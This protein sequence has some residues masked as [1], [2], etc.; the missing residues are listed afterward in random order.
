MNMGIGDSL[1]KF[2][3]KVK[4]DL[5][6]WN[7]NRII[8]DLEKNQVQKICAITKVTHLRELCVYYGR[9]MPKFKTIIEEFGKPDQY[10]MRQTRQKKIPIPENKQNYTR[11][12]VDKFT[13]E[14]IVTFCDQRSLQVPP[15]LKKKYSFI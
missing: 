4:E 6:G 12:I 9:P 3:H 13:K 5:K 11:H 8:K 2:G 15:E 1:K 10:G 7:E 14:E